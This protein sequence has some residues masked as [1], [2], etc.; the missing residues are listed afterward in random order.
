LL[1]S[2]RYRTIKII[3]RCP[4]SEEELM[5]ANRAESWVVYRRPIKGSADGVNA[6]CETAEWDEME[7]DQPGFLTL[8]QAGITSEG[9]AER[10]AR[11]TSGDPVPRGPRT[12]PDPQPGG[13][14]PPE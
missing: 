13:P 3:A 8:I 5:A 1:S 12:A 11:G 7:R 2:R 9:V 6:V 10:L 4:G 14:P